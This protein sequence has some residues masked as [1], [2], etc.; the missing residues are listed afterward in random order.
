MHSSPW[1]LFPFRA[2]CAIVFKDLKHFFRD[3]S[4]WSQLFL[5]FA[6]MVVYIYSFKFLPLDRAAMPSFYLQ[7]LIAF[8]NLGMVGFVTSAIAVR[9]VFPAVSLEGTSFWII[10][11]APLD[12]CIPVGKV[13]E[14]PAPPPR[15]RRSA[16][17]SLEYA[18]QR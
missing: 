2:R 10:R 3:T 16:Y 4:Q 7:N 9:F 6:L 15:A 12:Q 18:P 5:L 11:S 14:Q 13:L 8:L 1:C 17:H